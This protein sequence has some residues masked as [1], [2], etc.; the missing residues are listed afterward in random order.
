MKSERVESPAVATKKVS[1]LIA[2]G[3]AKSLAASRYSDP[4]NPYAGLS[5]VAAEAVYHACG[6]IKSKLKVY[7][8][9]LPGRK[10][11]YTFLKDESGKVFDPCANQFNKK[12]D[13]SVARH[14]SLVSTEPSIRA[15]KLLQMIGVP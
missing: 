3:Q 11:V 9:P 4:M 15:R 1:D 14:G 8:M 2:A 10:E 12:V 6:G 13:Y 5:Y 7:F